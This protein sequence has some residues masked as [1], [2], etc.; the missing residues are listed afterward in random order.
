MLK[1]FDHSI[2]FFIVKR[3]IDPIKSK[4]PSNDGPSCKMVLLS[5]CPSWIVSQ[6]ASP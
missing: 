6:L 3:E 5:R 1:D 4:S 2:N